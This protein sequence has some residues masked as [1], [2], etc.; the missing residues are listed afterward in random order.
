[1]IIYINNIS[2]SMSDNINYALKTVSELK[3]LCR[4][5]ILKGIVIKKGQT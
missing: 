4:G 5:S 3:E 1:M 2:N